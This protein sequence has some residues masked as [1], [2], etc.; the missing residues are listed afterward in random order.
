MLNI[1]IA[2]SAIERIPESLWAHSEVLKKSKILNKKPGQILLDRSYH[3]RAMLRLKDNEKR[4][5][6]DIVHFCLLE[7]LGSPLNKEG[8]LKIFVHTCND[9]VIDV[10]HE[11]R[12]PKK[13]GR[14]D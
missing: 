14:P 6:P 2:E 8:F 13:V 4:G 10:A 7:A 3:H 1:I 11:T 5:R 9:Y 12:I